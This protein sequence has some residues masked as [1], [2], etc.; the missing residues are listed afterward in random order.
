MFSA[1]WLLKWQAGYLEADAEGEWERDEDQQHGEGGEQPAAH[2]DT[3]LLLV[4][5]DI[6]T[7]YL[8]YIYSISTV[9]LQYILVYL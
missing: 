8:Q 5:V 6:S 1:E 4:C 2:A 3:R 7:V 9:Y